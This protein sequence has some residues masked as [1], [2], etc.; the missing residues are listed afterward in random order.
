[1]APADDPPAD[2]LPA[3]DVPADDLPG[4]DVRGDDV[5]AGDRPADGGDQQPTGGGR[6]R[7][8]ARRAA[9]LGAFRVGVGVAAVLGA[10]L[11]AAVVANRRACAAG[12]D[13]A[14]DCFSGF[15]DAS[16]YHDQA[17]LMAHGHWFQLTNLTAEGPAVLP[18]ALHPPLY[19]LYLSVFSRFG[20]TGWDG[21]RLATIPIGVAAIVVIALLARRVGGERAGVLASFFTACYPLFWI[22]DTIV[23]S[24]SLF[25]LL[26]ALVALT[27]YRL[28]DTPGVVRSLWVGG[29]IGLAALTRAEGMLLLVLVLAPIT[30]GRPDVAR[31]ERIRNA[32]LGLVAAGLVLAPWTIY[33]AVRFGEPL[34]GATGRVFQQA[35]CDPTYYGELTGYWSICTASGVP[36]GSDESQVDPILF[37]EA[38]AYL[39]DNLGRLPVVVLA[40]E[41]RLTY[42]FRPDQQVQLNQAFEN[43]GR[44]AAVLERWAFYGVAVL[45]IAGLYVL[46]RR[47]VPMSPLLGLV[48][49]SVLATSFLA[50]GVTR[51]RAP[52]DVALVVGAAVAVG[53][54][55]TWNERRRAAADLP[56]AD[57][58]EDDLPEDDLPEDDLPGA[59]PLQ[60]TS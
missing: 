54:L 60:G 51:Y 10:V 25:A 30:L 16:F 46:W 47:R 11:R 4:D 42:L 50:S 41:G 27:A 3:D 22:H 12:A 21:H 31:R 34:M 2:D 43:R 52:A 58:P 37:D 7:A 29:L 44:T 5:P 19:S 15:N 40:R 48:G 20:I 24:E 49:V 6:G 26:A 17:N 33:N 28:W 38:R 36:P 9:A 45:G 8:L 57:L 18:T 35:Q 39:G 53:A 56:E 55:L 1:M 59:E 13:A 14:P 32:V 23:M